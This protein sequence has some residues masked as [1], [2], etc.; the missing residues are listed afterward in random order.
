MDMLFL[1]TILLVP[2]TLLPI[3]NPIGN[4]PVFAAAVAGAGGITQQKVARQVALNSWFLL[5]GAMFVGSHVLAFFGISLPVVRIAGGL[6]VATTGWRYL[7]EQAG[8]IQRAAEPATEW[9]D[10]ALKTRSFYPISFPLTVGPGSITA[11]ITLGAA[12]PVGLFDRVVSFGSSSLGIALT[13][14]IIYLFYRYASRIVDMLGKPGTII[15][16]RLF[17]FILLCVGIQIAWLGATELLAQAS[18]N[19][20]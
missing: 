19:A 3:L 7:N 8:D 15:V 2:L 11:A 20:A 16:R 4:A 6:L 5:I 17:A 13:S 18:M 10:E 1:K 9:T 12:A 14:A